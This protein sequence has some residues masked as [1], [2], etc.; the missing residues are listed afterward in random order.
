MI[1]IPGFRM[2]MEGTP[3]AMT[4]IASRFHTAPSLA[5]PLLALVLLLCLASGSASVPY[6]LAP[7]AIGALSRPTLLVGRVPLLK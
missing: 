2:E 7:P 5:Q 6:D 4:G 3:R 1:R